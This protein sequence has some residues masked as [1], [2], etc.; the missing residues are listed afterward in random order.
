MLVTTPSVVIESVPPPNVSGA[1]P[2]E[3]APALLL[4]MSRVPAATVI[5]LPAATVVLGANVIAPAPDLTNVTAAPLVFNG[6]DVNR[7][8]AVLTVTVPAPVR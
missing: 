3:V 1:P 7:P 6:P 4:L 5:A 2:M 8:P